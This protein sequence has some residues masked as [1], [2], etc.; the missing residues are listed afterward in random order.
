MEVWLLIEV[1]LYS[2][3]LACCKKTV[4]MEN[5]EGDTAELFSCPRNLPG[6]LHDQFLRRPM[7]TQSHFL[8]SLSCET[9]PLNPTQT[10]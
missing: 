1:M 4:K 10:N 9:R 7:L 6:Q 2:P 3:R 5:E 8:S